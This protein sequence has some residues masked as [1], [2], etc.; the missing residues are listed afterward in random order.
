M[1][2]NPNV[3]TEKFNG[4]NLLINTANSAVLGLDDK[5]YEEYLEILQDKN[6]NEDLYEFLV[7]NEFI[8]KV[9]EFTKGVNVKNAYIHITDR[10]NLKCK[11]CYSQD[12]RCD[13]KEL[14][15][16]EL[17]KVVSNLK[18]LNLENIIISGGEPMIRKDLDKILELIKTELK[19][20]NLI[21]ITNGTV[22]NFDMLENIAPYV[23]VLSVSLD[24]YS[25]DC[26]AFLREDKIFDRIME[27]IDRAK[28]LDITLSILPTINHKN[29]DYINEYTKLSKKLGTN[30]SFSL[31]TVK[32]DDENREFV[33]TTDD[34]KKIV[35]YYRVNEIE[36]E[37]VPL[38][39]CLEGKC[40]CGTGEQLISVGTDG[41]LYPCHMLMEDEFKMGNLLEKDVMSLL[42]HNAKR[43]YGVEVDDMDGCK[44]CEFK[45]LCG[46]GCRA[47]A[48]LYT[49]KIASKDPFC[50]MYY[51]FFDEVMNNLIAG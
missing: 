31:F 26:K 6:V 21:V 42:V 44:E 34:L 20:D 33:L 8:K 11:G 2:K 41:S 28:E 24:T 49:D 22:H 38:K 46:G 36:V 3:K 35:D 19:P 29:V 48:Y 7:E 45:Y 47:R 15:F 27:F 18:P 13:K 23:D 17:T 14:S 4:A 25:S 50:P 12:E 16:N 32:P 10:C 51:G 1:Y 39:D 40:N 43:K 37:D 30:I 5:T 9:N